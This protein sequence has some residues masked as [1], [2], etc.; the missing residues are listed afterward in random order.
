V[1]DAPTVFVVDDDAALRKGLAMSLRERGLEVETFESAEHFLET[2]GSGRHGCVIL[3]VRM[4]YMSGP[5][6]QSEMIRRGIRLPVIFISGHG[7]VPLAT[8]AMRKGAVDFLEKP[9]SLDVL[10]QRVNEALAVDR[11]HHES[12]EIEKSVQARFQRLSDR[13]REVMRLLVAGAAT[14]TSKT[15]ARQLGISSRTVE[16]YRARLM[17]KM[18]A[19]SITDL[20][21]MAKICGVYESE[22]PRS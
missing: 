5:E 11:R 12:S 22:T 4:P 10:I 15:I 8:A 21:A 17:E 1:I 6:L 20:A 13:E 19:R 7:D 14:A 16:T 2:A 9:Y 18:R 3:D